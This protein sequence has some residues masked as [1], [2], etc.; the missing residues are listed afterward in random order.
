M[1]SAFISAFAQHAR[2]A[3]AAARRARSCIFQRPCLL[4]WCSHQ[5]VAAPLTRNPLGASQFVNVSR[6]RMTLSGTSPKERSRA[7][8]ERIERGMKA[9]YAAWFRVTRSQPRVVH[10][11]VVL[12]V[13]PVNAYSTRRGMNARYAEVVWVSAVPPSA[14]ARVASRWPVCAST[15]LF[16]NA[17]AQ[18]ARAAD[19]A[20]RR[21]RSGGFQRQVLLQ[22]N[23]HQSGRRR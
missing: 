9:R 14:V 13:V 18:P 6:S 20:A 1:R 3:D 7:R 8:K 22:C 16:S 23:S 5:S 12:H 11:R 17:R 4:Q 19:A 15:Q 21:A 10:R 2:A